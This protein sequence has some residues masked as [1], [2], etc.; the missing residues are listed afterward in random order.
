MSKCITCGQEIPENNEPVSITLSTADGMVIT[1]GNEGF[2]MCKEGS[3]TGVKNKDGKM[4]W[5]RAPQY[6][7][8]FN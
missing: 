6:E 3:F 8:P 1:Q 5:T 4:E 2:K 7:N